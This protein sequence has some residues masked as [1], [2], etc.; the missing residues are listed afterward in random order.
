MPCKLELQQ[1]SNSKMGHSLNGIPFPWTR[2]RVQAPVS[3][4]VFSGIFIA[5]TGLTIEC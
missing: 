2:Y 4:A 3:G 1:M 5:K